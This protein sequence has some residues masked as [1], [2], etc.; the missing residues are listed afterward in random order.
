MLITTA[1]WI[2]REKKPKLPV[3][4]N[5][6]KT[7]RRPKQVIKGGYN[8]MHILLYVINEAHKR[9]HVKAGEYNYAPS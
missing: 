7:R 1:Q 6:Q 4:L 8:G 3:A 2:W 9:G 5:A